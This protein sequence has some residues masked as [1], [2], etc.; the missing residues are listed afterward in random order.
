MLRRDLERHRGLA[1]ALRAADEHQLAGADAA[2]ER[3]IEWREAQ[4]DRL[5]L[6]DDALA[7]LL[8]QAGQHLDRASAGEE[9]AVCLRDPFAR[10]PGAPFEAGPIGESLEYG[11]LRRCSARQAGAVGNRRRHR[12]RASGARRATSSVSGGLMGYGHGRAVRWRRRRLTVPS[13]WTRGEAYVATVAPRHQSKYLTDRRQRSRR[14]RTQR[15]GPAPCQPVSGPR[16]LSDAQGASACS[17]WR[18]WTTDGAANGSPVHGVVTASR[19]RGKRRDPARPTDR[20][21]TGS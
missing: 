19:S 18:N 8:G 9:R 2:A 11:V 10:R 14:R 3:A 16:F 7:D 17:L 5:V 6:G 20:P 13:C 1:C 12:S 21:S 15:D 4:R